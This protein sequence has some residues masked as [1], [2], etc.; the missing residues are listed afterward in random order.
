MLVLRFFQENV[1]MSLVP[2]M[3]FIFFVV[4]IMQQKIRVSL[5]SKHFRTP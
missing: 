2:V 1:M 5:L 4:L 3:Q